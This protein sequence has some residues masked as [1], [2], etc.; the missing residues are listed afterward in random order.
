[1][2][3]RL[4]VSLKGTRIGFIEFD[5]DGNSREFSYDEEYLASPEACPISLS[6]PLRQQPYNSLETRLF[7]ENLL[8]PAVRRSRR[9]TIR[10]PPWSIRTSTIRW[11][12]RSAAITNSRT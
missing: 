11:R 7:F 6:L 8:P 12:W 9:F 10:C 2:K 3:E 4:I 1:M 5:S